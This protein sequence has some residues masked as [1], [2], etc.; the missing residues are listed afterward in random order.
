MGRG[1]SRRKAK[2]SKDDSWKYKT[3]DK[4]C[5]LLNKF[6][7]EQKSVIKEGE[8]EQILE[9]LRK[10]L[11]TTFRVSTSNDKIA[12]E[13]VAKIRALQEDM[14]KSGLPSHQII[15]EVKWFPGDGRC[16]QV[17]LSKK[18]MS[19]EIPEA[20]PLYD[21]LL[22]E[23]ERG[24]ISRQEVVSMIPPLF[25]DVQP[26]H[27]VLDTCAAPGSKTAQLMESIASHDSEVTGCIVANDMDSKR[28][29]VL[30]KQTQRQRELYPNMI[31][32][33]HNAGLFP[34][35]A[36][37]SPEDPKQLV[38]KQFDRILCDV[39]CSGDGTFRKSLD[40]WGRWTPAFGTS[41]NKPQ[42]QILLRAMDL[43]K[44]GGR[45]VYSTCSLNPIEDEAVLMNC[46]KS[47]KH[48]FELVD[49][50]DMLPGLKRD[51]G[52]NDW[53]LVS[54]NCEDIYKKWEEVTPVVAAN[55]HFNEGMF[56]CPDIEKY[57][58][59]RSMRFKPQYH[60]TGGF[61]VAVL[62]KKK[63][64][65]AHPRVRQPG[66]GGVPSWEE[67]VLKGDYKSKKPVETSMFNMTEAECAD[68]VKALNLKD[69]FPARNLFCR[70]TG[71]KLRRTYLFADLAKDIIN[72]NNMSPCTDG[73]PR[74]KIVTGGLR[75]AEKNSGL[76]GGFRSVQEAADLMARHTNSSSHATVSEAVFKK[77]LES[78][79]P[80][81][82][83]DIAENVENDDEKASL[84][85][86]VDGPAVISLP[87]TH[88]AGACRKHLNSL[89]LWADANEINRLRSALNL[90][91]PQPVQKKRERDEAAA[92]ET[93]ELK[94]PK[95]DV[96]E[97]K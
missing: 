52:V 73:W 11:L 48:D 89:H 66:E 31:V 23:T 47:T 18:E 8:W 62:H 1:H 50:S 12:K 28:C 70:R 94:K 96:E 10:P 69:T 67:L 39:V 16:W 78:E 41:T 85:A 65:T 2:K 14:K 77:L 25:L 92:E 91:I 26:H 79:S 54:K 75:I 83:L 43:L 13:T 44:E 49:C 84:L 80:P 58:L 97:E 53:V 45:L 3:I 68:V 87:G 5:E 88:V 60:N 21:F 20:R 51:P 32:T 36:V 38:R 82:R 71:G 19:R 30:V 22:S 17:D 95:E 76:G 64:N 4:T 46:M 27:M 63:D 86:L 40:L 15:E 61:F 57:N 24:R 42:C 74:L 6:Y 90:P 93:G 37:P 35:I 34:M 9:T 55:E 33:N 56:P 29:E 7:A 59:H 72:G 81:W